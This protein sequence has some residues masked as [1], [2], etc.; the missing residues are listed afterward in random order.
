MKS[1]VATG[2]KHSREM[3]MADKLYRVVESKSGRSCEITTIVVKGRGKDAI[4]VVRSAA[5]R[6][7]AR[8]R[9]DRLAAMGIAETKKEAVR[10]WMNA[11]I[12][13]RK[14]LM[15]SMTQIEKQISWADKWIARNG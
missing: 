6:Y 8:I 1:K 11:S 10:L 9:I 2:R 12:M 5:I 7:M 15:D 13:H 4:R 3:V 14:D